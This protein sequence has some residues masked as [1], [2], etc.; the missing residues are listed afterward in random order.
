[1]SSLTQH[2]YLKTENPDLFN[3]LDPSAHIGNNLDVQIRLIHGYAGDIPQFDTQPI[4]SKS[5]FKAL[6]EAGYDVEL[7]IKEDASHMD[8]RNDCA[9]K[10]A[11]ILTVQQVMD[12]A[13][14]LSQ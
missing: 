6:T 4:E 9:D 8:L 7:I 14:S 2:N 3:L 10:E 1:Y 11:F 13:R 12:M 5:F